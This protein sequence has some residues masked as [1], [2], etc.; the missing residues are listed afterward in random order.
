[1]EPPLAID[2]VS[3]VTQYVGWILTL[4]ALV[5]ELFSFVHCAFQRGDAF[6]AVGT[7][8][9]GAWLAITGAAAALTLLL[10]VGPISLLGLIGV[11]AGAVY[12]LDVRPAIKDATHG[13]GPW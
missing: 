4:F 9:K 12:T 1:M 5:L 2:I 10:G 13:N 11:I 8:P 6:R 7:L 3:P